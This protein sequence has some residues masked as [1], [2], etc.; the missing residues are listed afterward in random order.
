MGVARGVCLLHHEGSAMAFNIG[1]KVV[2]VDDVFSSS[3][4]D[5]PNKPRRGRIYT[6]RGTCFY[7]YADAPYAPA[8]YLEEL[9]NPLRIVAQV[10]TA[11]FYAV[12]LPFWAGRF[13][14]VTERKTDISVFTD[15]LTDAPNL[16][17]VD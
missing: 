10:D 11:K 7:D 4:N 12:E 15:M 5:I 1:Q 8:V 3:W 17:P 16:E 2:C 9:L 6:V 14:P 13:R